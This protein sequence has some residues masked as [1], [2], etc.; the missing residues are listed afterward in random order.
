[1]LFPELMDASPCAAAYAAQPFSASEIDD[2]QDAA[3]IWATIVDV[4]PSEEMF[5]EEDVNDQ[6]EAA[7]ARAG[8][9]ASDDIRVQLQMLARSAERKMDTEGSDEVLEWLLTAIEGIE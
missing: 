8:K 3:R 9:K 2:H 7:A 5:T 1:M 4:R 6:C